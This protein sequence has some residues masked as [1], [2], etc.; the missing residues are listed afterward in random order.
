MI[1]KKIK[2]RQYFTFLILFV[3]YSIQAQI[4]TPSNPTYGN[5]QSTASSDYYSQLIG[6]S[7]TE[8]RNALKN[9]VV[10]STTK[11]QNYGDVWLMLREA[12]ENPANTNQVWQIYIESG[13]DKSEQN[14]GGSTGWNREHI[15]PQTR[16][17]F[18]DGT[19]TSS[20]G[21]DVYFS[22]S[23]SQI[24]HAHG[25][26]HH[27]RAS[28]VGENSNRGNLDFGNV[29]GPRT[30]NSYFYEPPLSAKGDVAR[31]LFYMEIRYDALSLAAGDQDGQ[32]IGDL[33]ALL[34]WDKLDAP[35]DFEMRRNNVVYDWQNNRNPFIDNPNLVD[36]IWGDK[37][38][39]AWPGS[40]SSGIK[41]TSIDAF[42]VVQ[43]GTVSESKTYLVEG[44]ELDETLNIDAP[45]HFEISLNDIDFVKH[46]EL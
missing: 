42:P 44:T 45:E 1:Q 38:G 32:I 4:G 6:L 24:T 3:A 8:L 2:Y 41:L 35:D 19:S 25:D 16:G 17:G 33:T 13:I 36:Y 15:F 30:K 11:G 40:T 20:D 26:A 9:I 23:S 46:L 5:V 43:Y 31:A 21:K 27:L 12:D 10:N 22:T 14:T 29:S 28:F 37:Q 18:A 39:L 7:G 34:Q